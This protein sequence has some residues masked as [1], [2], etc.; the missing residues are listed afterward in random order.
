MRNPMASRRFFV[1]VIVVAFLFCGWLPGLRGAVV[2]WDFNGDLTSANG[3]VSLIA[4]ATLPATQPVV[5]FTNLMIGGQPAPVAAFSRGTFFSLRHN[6]TPN[7]GGSLVNQYTLILDVMFPNRPA[8]WAA[9]WQT[10]PGNRNDGDWFINPGRG[11]GIDGNYQGTVADG[12]WHRLALVMDGLGGKLTSFIDGVPVASIYGVAVDGHLALDTQVLL[13]T[14]DNLETAPGF[15]N[16]VQLWD[17]A[18]P[19]EDLA[20]LGGPTADGI[21]V[22]AKPTLNLLAPN[23]GEIFSGGST[24]TVAW[25]VT[26]PSGWMTIDLYRGDTLYRQLARV[27]LR[28]PSYDWVVDPRLGDTNNY[29][30]KLMSTWAAGVE[31][32]SDAPF[33]VTGTG[34]PPKA[35]FGQPLQVNGGFEQYLANWQTVIG[36]PIVMTTGATLGKGQPHSGARFFYGGLNSPGDSVVRQEI[37]LLATGFV[38]ADIDNGAMLEADAWLKNYYP[39]SWFD[40]QVYYRVAYLDGAGR[41]LSSVRC[42]VAADRVWVAR[43]LLGRVPAGTR[44]LALEIVGKH[45]RDPDNDSMADDLVVR[46]QEALPPVTPQITKLPMLQDTRPDAM[47]LL[48][49]TD[50]NLCDHAVEW[51]VSNVTEHTLR[52]VESLEIDTSHFVQRTTIPGL[53]AQ[54]RYVYRVRS[55]TNTSPVFSFRTAPRRDS[56]FTIAWW[57]D[58]HDATNVMRK[59]VTNLKAYD[60]DL[61]AVAGD[62]VVTGNDLVHWHNHWFKMLEYLNLAQTTPVIFCRG[63]HDGEHALAYAYSVLPG[64]ESWFAFDYGNCR[65]IFLDSETD[66]AGTPQQFAWLKDELER[67]ETKRAAFRI[68]CFHRPPFMNWWNTGPVTGEPF[69]RDD[70]V[71]LFEQKHVDLVISGHSHFYNRGMSNG[72]MYVV[73]AGGGGHLEN[74]RVASW[75]LFTVEYQKFHYDIMQVDGDILFWDTFDDDNKPL[76]SFTLRTS[77]PYLG[78]EKLP[79]DDEFE[80]SLLGKPGLSYVLESSTDLLHWTTLDTY[81][82]PPEGTPFVTRFSGKAALG[83]V[84][85]RLGP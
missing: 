66:T 77:L 62:L 1:G 34:P 80:L 14:D 32:F 55:G 74:I 3:G 72:V 49:E 78:W 63:N 52:R 9:L 58:N 47:T 39:A 37:D 10:D 59:H 40:D 13:F 53:T 7:G 28:Q 67:P 25:A 43:P 45:R 71:P 68:V 42:L 18:L 50:G 5:V 60:P 57:G 6:F 36:R 79:A 12:V 75:P 44:K 54:T 29:R 69:V 30:I 2:Q 48:W 23:G 17:A 70:W 51:G 38:P 84:R 35:I 33:T 27:P 56:P 19:A 31:D 11:L 76:D 16:C 64:N 4:G 15:V 41:E 20:A 73:T 26:N 21:P 46:L 81:V 65:F 85:A 82:V 8:G 22:P 61:I 24:Q 83:F